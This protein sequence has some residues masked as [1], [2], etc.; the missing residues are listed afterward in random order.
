MADDLSN[1]LD[2]AVARGSA[3]V[4]SLPSEGMFRNY[5]TRFLGLAPE[6]LWVDGVPSE[7]PLITQLVRTSEPCPVT[8]KALGA[9]VQFKARVLRDEPEHVVNGGLT[10]PAL[11]LER[12]GQVASLQRRESYRVKIAETT[13]WKVEAWR[14]SGS[15]DLHVEPGPNTKLE[16]SIVDLSATGMGALNRIRAG[17]P[18]LTASQRL[19]LILKHH[20]EPV[21]LESTV[22]SV[23]DGSNDNTSIIGIRFENLQSGIEGRRVTAMLTKIVGELSRAERQKLKGLV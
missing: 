12:P 8:F 13:D 23:R 4:L 21:L 22:M 20:D 17:Q 6:G 3:A 18:P 1:Q 11:L 5:R 19:R 15:A 7:V 2:E 14:I 16:L 10:V 9:A